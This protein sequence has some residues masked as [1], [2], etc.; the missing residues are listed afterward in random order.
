MGKSN[1]KK[2]LIARLICS[3]CVI[4]F[5][6]LQLFGLWD[7]ANFVAVPLLGVTLLLQTIQEWK[8]NRKVAIFGLVA[9][10]FVISC[11]V[12]MIFI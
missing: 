10:V 8:S 9:A 4:I 7:K 6:L 11:S 1:H 3:V 5:A 12:A 2:F